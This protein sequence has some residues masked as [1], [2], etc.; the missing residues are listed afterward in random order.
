MMNWFWVAGLFLYI[1][2]FVIAIQLTVRSMWDKNLANKWNIKCWFDFFAFIILSIMPLYNTVVAFMVCK[3][4]YCQ[5]QNTK[6]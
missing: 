6:T 4:S 5:W 1:V 3:W 2:S